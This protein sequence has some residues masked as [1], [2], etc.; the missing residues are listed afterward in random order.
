M[1][2]KSEPATLSTRIQNSMANDVALQMARERLQTIEQNRAMLLAEFES[3]RQTDIQK[4][5]DVVLSGGDFESDSLAYR[6]ESLREKIAAHDAAI[7]QQKQAV[8]RA[9]RTASHAACDIAAANHR[10]AVERLVDAF[11]GVR[12]AVAE[13]ND[14]RNLLAQNEVTPDNRFAAFN[15]SELQALSRRLNHMLVNDWTPW[16]QSLE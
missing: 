6:R 13:I 5:A 10:Q 4:M 9:V 2:T 12:E 7:T 16:L 14:I 15:H 3:A 1:K 8:Q 11:I